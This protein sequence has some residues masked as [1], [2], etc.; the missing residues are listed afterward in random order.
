[1]YASI[2]HGRFLRSGS[3]RVVAL[4]SLTILIVCACADVSGTG[5]SD[6]PPLEKMCE[7]GQVAQAAAYDLDDGSFRWASCAAENA[8]RHV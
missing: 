7:H 4:T 3:I 1:M 5:E 2:R 6:S 8:Y